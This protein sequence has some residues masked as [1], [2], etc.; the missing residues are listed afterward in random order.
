MAALTF[1]P[2]VER[3]LVYKTLQEIRMMVGKVPGGIGLTGAYGFT[4]PKFSFIHNHL[5]DWKRVSSSP[6]LWV[7]NGAT[8]GLGARVEVYLPS[9]YRNWLDVLAPI[10]RHED[11]HVDDAKAIVT[12]SLPARLKQD[13]TFKAFF[14]DRTPIPEVTYRH[15]FPKR[16]A[17]AVEAD[18]NDL[19]NQAVARRDTEPLYR[20][21]ADE[22]SLALRRHHP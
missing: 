9:E 3:V 21:V 22:I 14:I 20:P 2:Q 17:D 12:T 10:T 11:L 1:R 19:W 6:S 13:S 4:D 8:V 16:M 5:T 7:F 18:F 15:M